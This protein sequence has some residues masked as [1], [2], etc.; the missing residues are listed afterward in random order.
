[1]RLTILSLALA[2][3]LQACGSGEQSAALPNSGAGAVTLGIQEKAY[4]VAPVYRFA[5]ISNG[6]YFYTASAEEASLIRLNYPDFRF[7][8]P[9]F[10]HV[11]SGDGQ[12]VFR[13]ANLVNGGYFY[14]ASTVER[15]YVLSDPVLK[16][17]FRLDAATFQVA[18]DTDVSALPVYRAA[19]RV[20]GAY[21]YS[22]SR[23]E[24]NYA[25]SVLNVWNDEGAQFKVPNVPLATSSWPVVSFRSYTNVPGVTTF[26][27]DAYA[28]TVN[29]FNSFAVADTRLLAVKTPTACVSSAG[30]TCAQKYD[31]ALVNFCLYDAAT[32]Q[33]KT[34]HILLSALVEPANP[35]ELR[36]KS[37]KSLGNCIESSITAATVNADGSFTSVT[38]TNL[39][40]NE[41]SQFM[42]TGLAGT[43]TGR[44]F[45]V[46][47]NGQTKYMILQLLQGQ[48]Y[49][50]YFEN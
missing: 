2:T 3:M 8:G 21:L 30:A 44:A 20:N 9:A 35:T 45:K 18:L 15:D 16:T 22:L 29:E 24:I 40:T 13:F 23:D 6:A 32:T 41:F 28:A 14:T 43:L 39:T 17:R 19:N 7:E 33:F 48:G 34:R 12:T 47:G 50:A 49:S 27:P 1:M 31:G 26:A 46:S 5:K 4:S 38:G 36:G 42:S 25:V 37:F 10:H 11:T